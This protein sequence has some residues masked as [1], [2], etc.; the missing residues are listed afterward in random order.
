MGKTLSRNLVPFSKRKHPH[1]RGE[2]VLGFDVETNS[3]ETPPQAWGRPK[4]FCWWASMGGNTP[5]GV[6]KTTHPR[7][8]SLLS[9]KHP[10]RRG[11]DPV[12]L[13]TALDQGETPP[14]AWGRLPAK[15]VKRA[16]ERNTP[17]GVGKTY[18]TPK[19]FMMRLKHPH[20]RG[21]DQPWA[22]RR[23][24]CLETPPQAWGRLGLIVTFSPQGGN[25]PTGVGK[26]NFCCTRLATPRKHPH[27]RGEDSK[28]SL[29]FLT[30][31]LC[32]HSLS[33]SRTSCNPLMRTSSRR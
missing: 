23:K 17:T 29:N 10:H 4:A 20:R 12:I 6:G 13:H 16:I 28:E 19:N 27:R 25:T 9:L 18:I 30:N 3:I 24:K 26:T 7:H 2:D 31:A 33:F 32:H 14:Q 15:T 8:L 1:R 21:E 5:T 11:E 22:F